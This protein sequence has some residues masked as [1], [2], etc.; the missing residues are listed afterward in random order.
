MV[1]QTVL[2]LER[3]GSE[4]SD[5]VIV[6]FVREGRLIARTRVERSGSFVASGLSPGIYSVIGTGTDGS[7]AIAVEVVSHDEEQVAATHSLSK[8]ETTSMVTMPELSAAVVP[9][10]DFLALHDVGL[11]DNLW[12]NSE[13]AFAGGGSGVGT[14]GVGT[15]GGAGG[16]GGGGGAIGALLGGAVGGGVGYLLG[17]DGNGGD[18]STPAS[19]SQ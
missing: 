12:Q 6:C 17:R 19:P 7:F 2:I 13:G 3:G 5:D 16:A 11:M 4:K 8:Y 18:G 15:G 1:L 10:V 14:G 9:S